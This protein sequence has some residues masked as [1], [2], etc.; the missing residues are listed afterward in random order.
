MSTPRPRAT[1]GDD[2]VDPASL[3]TLLGAY[4]TGDPEG[5]ADPEWLR[6]ARLRRR[7][8]GERMRAYDIATARE[9]LPSADE[10]FISRKIDGEF[11]VLV[12]RD[13]VC[14]TLNPGGTV[15]VGA[16]FHSEAAALLTKAGVRSAVVGGE[17]YVRR[18]DGRRPRVHDVT[19]VARKPADAAAVAS[20]CFAVFD[21]YELDGTDPGPPYGEVLA[22]AR[23]LFEGGDRVHV[24]DTVRG[25]RERVLAQYRQWVETEQGEGVVA[26]SDAAG[27]YKIKPRHTLDLA[28]VGFSEGI[29]ERSGL[30]HSLL[31]A[32]PVDADSFQILGRVGGGF[33]DEL[34]AILLAE[35][36]TQ[37]VESDY[38]EV[39]S[40]QVGYRMIAPGPVA[41][42]SC[43]DVIATTSLGSS[44]DRMV[45]DWDAGRRRWEGVRRLPLCSLLS[46]QFLRL[47][48]DKR[49]TP[50]DVRLAQLADITEI[51]EVVRN[52]GEIRLPK[53]RV[54]ERAVATKV[55][56][57]ATLVRKLLLW[58]TNKEEVSRDHPAYVLH[59]TDYSPNRETPLNHEIRVSSSEEQ[60][61]ALY[62]QWRQENF[63]GGWKL[64]E[65]PD[66]AAP[67]PE[68]APPP[69]AASSKAAAAAASKRSRRSAAKPR[70]EP[71]GE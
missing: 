46:P 68:P 3:R 56:K 25:D 42:I 34:R 22:A 50:E 20:L 40:D 37:V 45:L 39:N 19:R 6:T 33:S 53:S 44:I 66:A 10:Y 59:L 27:L 26:R 64:E 58:K 1:R 30:L 16:A 7:Q 71:P 28:V 61:R 60:I 63:V 31:V 12:Y 17:L 15:R 24:V 54:L 49:A 48:P 62:L 23:R 51:P 9:R 67:A 29:D 55:L 57:G 52:A 70:Q 14:L 4:R 47:R 38:V 32:L 41:E 5:L 13:G 69:K 43:L 18:D 8:L 65:G 35:L 2:L 21:F 11:T 36:A